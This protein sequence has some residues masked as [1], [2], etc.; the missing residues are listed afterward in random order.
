MNIFQLIR[1]RIAAVI[2]VVFFSIVIC[3]CGAAFTF[4]FAP[5]QA[6][7]ANRISNLPQMDA[8][9]VV[10]ANPGTEILITGVLANNPALLADSNL[11]AYELERWDVTPPNNDNDTTP[12]GSWESVETVIPNLTLEANGQNLTILAANTASLSGALHEEIVRGD[13]FET[14]SYNGENLPEGSLRYQGFFNG[15]LTTVLGQKASTEGI[16]PAK[17]YAGDRVAFEQSEKDAAKWMLV[18]G[19]AMMICSPLFLV[20]GGVGAIFGRNTRGG[21]GFKMRMR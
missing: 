13:G 8:G 1:E 11:V 15:D 3:I 2:G 7:E 9:Y 6:L 18:A 19:I 14:A 16:V 12:D 20:L 4:Y 10:S 21:G 5:Q 17:L